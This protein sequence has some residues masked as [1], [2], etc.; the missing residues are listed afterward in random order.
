MIK[1]AI[2]V[3]LIVLVINVIFNLL[4]CK[5]QIHGMVNLSMK[6]GIWWEYG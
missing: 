6:K 2:T 3:V 4:F 5:E 1:L